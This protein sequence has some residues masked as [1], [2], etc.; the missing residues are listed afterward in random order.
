MRFSKIR[1]KSKEERLKNKEEHLKAK[2]KNV[3]QKERIKQKQKQQPKQPII[4]SPTPEQEMPDVMKEQKETPYTTS[5][6]PEAE[7]DL[8]Q[9]KIHPEDYLEI[10]IVK[11]SRV[12]DI[13]AIP[14]DKKTFHYKKQEYKII[15]DGIYLLPT[16]SGLLM[17]SSFYREG[18]YEPTSFKNTNKG[19]TGKALSLLYM[20]QLYTSL[21]YAEDNKYNLFIVILLLACLIGFGIGCYLIFT[22]TGTPPLPPEPIPIM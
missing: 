3:K 12:V 17:P 8:K 18:Y 1:V 14:I 10:N 15:E 21:L 13:F 20:E 6:C 9:I 5:Y 22:F 11:K 16:K 7:N 19:I 2:L 4:T